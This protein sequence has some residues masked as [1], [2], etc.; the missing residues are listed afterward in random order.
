M[1]PAASQANHES[2]RKAATESKRFKAIFYG[3]AQTARKSFFE[4]SCAN[5]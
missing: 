5:I 1:P 3:I 4:K 2:G